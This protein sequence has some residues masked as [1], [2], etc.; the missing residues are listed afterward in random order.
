[1]NT[2][3]SSTQKSREHDN[4]SVYAIGDEIQLQC[5]TGYRR[6]EGNT[7]LTCNNTGHWDGVPLLC[8]G[9]STCINAIALLSYTTIFLVTII[10]ELN[11]I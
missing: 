2:N 3:I 11:N 8:E 1:M 5:M 7:S 10:K 9:K 6:L 4:E